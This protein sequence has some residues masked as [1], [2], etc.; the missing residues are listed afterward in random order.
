MY[1][2]RADLERG[3][4]TGCRGRE[5][6]ALFCA[7]YIRVGVKTRC[8]RVATLTAASPQPA[9]IRCGPCICAPAAD[10][11]IPRSC[12]RVRGL[13]LRASLRPAFPRQL[14]SR[15]PA[16]C[17]CTRS[18]TTV[19]ETTGPTCRQA[20][21]RIVDHVQEQAG[22]RYERVLC[23]ADGVHIGRRERA[24]SK[25]LPRSQ[26]RKRRAVQG[27]RTSNCEG[28]ISA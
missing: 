14:R 16:S 4:W 22:D 1:H 20:V 10:F 7:A 25:K 15:L 8:Y 18:S 11:P 5:C 28:G 6:N 27:T 24:A 3:A 2:T 9:D 19:P 26:R 17:G 23:Q 21:A 13:C 12:S